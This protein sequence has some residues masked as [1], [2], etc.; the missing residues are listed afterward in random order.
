MSQIT[1]LWMAIFVF[2]LTHQTEEIFYSIGE[3][4]TAHPKPLWT[5]FVSRSLMVKMDTR[6]KRT[7][8]VVAQCLMLLAIAFFT[9]ESLF[10]TQIAITI[11]LCIMTVAFILH[12]ILSV[13]T[14]SSM[15]GLS[16]SVFPGLPVGLFL[17]YFTWHI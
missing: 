5:N 2:F 11:F 3:W 14:H 13:A 16:T 8:L 1:Q 9:H 17:L 10:A 7:L 6:F 15:P 4:H 12:I